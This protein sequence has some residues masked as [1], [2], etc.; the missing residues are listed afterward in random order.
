MRLID[1]EPIIK[2]LSAMKTQLGYDAIDIDGMI[3]ALREAEVMTD[4][5]PLNDPLTL[6][7]L[8]EMDDADVWVAYPP[9]LSGDRLIMHA[10]VEY[11][12]ESEN[13]WLTNNLGGR[14]ILDEVSEDGGIVYRR[15]PEEEI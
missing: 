9:D 14:S 3:K 5:P 12:N 10:L 1:G 7:E 15:K 2:N 4:A 6:E 13:V 11:D 8:R